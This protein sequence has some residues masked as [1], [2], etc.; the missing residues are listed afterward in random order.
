MPPLVFL[1]PSHCRLPRMKVAILLLNQAAG[2]A[3]LVMNLSATFDYPPLTR[4]WPWIAESDNHIEWHL[5]SYRVEKTYD[6]YRKT[7]LYNLINFYRNRISLD[8]N[9][10]AAASCFWSKGI[11]AFCFSCGLM[12]STLLDVGAMTG[13]PVFGD[14]INPPSILPLSKTI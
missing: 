11:N 6:Q 3:P 4:T 10:L 12:S 8:A 7:Y 14:E 9:F 1:A 2:Y 5:W 13:L